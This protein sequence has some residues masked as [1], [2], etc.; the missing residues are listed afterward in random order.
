MENVEVSKLVATQQ[1]HFASLNEGH[2]ASLNEGHFA[3][4]NEGLTT[5]GV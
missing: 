4:L 5:R 2:F 1:G 3:S